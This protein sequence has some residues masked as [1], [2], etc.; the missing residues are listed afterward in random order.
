MS[1][2]S[3]F[4]QY[5]TKVAKGVTAGS[6]SPDAMLNSF[7][8]RADSENGYA[9]SSGSFVT[10]VTTTGSYYNL[11]LFNSGGGTIGAVY[12]FYSIVRLG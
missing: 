10:Q 9:T 3:S 12:G 7:W 4:T 6:T 8:G 2:T 5:L 1:Y 11:V